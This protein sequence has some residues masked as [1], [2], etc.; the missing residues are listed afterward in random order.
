MFIPF[1]PLIHVFEYENFSNVFNT[2]VIN[3]RTSYIIDC[4]ARAVEIYVSALCFK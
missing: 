4:F 3:S 1:I 2:D